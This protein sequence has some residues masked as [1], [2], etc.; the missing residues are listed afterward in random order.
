MRIYIY[1]DWKPSNPK[2][3]GKKKRANNSPKNA[4]H[5]LYMIYIYPIG[6]WFRSSMAPGAP[7]G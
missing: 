5:I 2:N 7:V 3:G 6:D 1:I 4:T